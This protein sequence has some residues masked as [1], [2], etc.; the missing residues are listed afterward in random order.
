MLLH[1]TSPSFSS[2]SFGLFV[3]PPSSGRTSCTIYHQCMSFFPSTPPPSIPLPSILS[4]TKLYPLSSNFTKG[5]RRYTVV[6]QVRRQHYQDSQLLLEVCFSFNHPFFPFPSFSY[7]PL[8][9]PL[10]LSLCSPSFCLFHYCRFLTSR[11]TIVFSSFL[12]YFV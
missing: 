5:T 12:K 10:L 6:G 11:M 2:I 4:L 9:L 1:K 8:L 7:F 3:A